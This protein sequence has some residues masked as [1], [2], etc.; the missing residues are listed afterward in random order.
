MRIHLH[1]PTGRIV[2]GAVVGNMKEQTTAY[3]SEVTCNDCLATLSPTLRSSVTEV[4]VPPITCSTY[5]YG[6]HTNCPSSVECVAVGLCPMCG[7]P[8]LKD[9]IDQQVRHMVGL[10]AVDEAWTALATDCRQRSWVIA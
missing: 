2:C 10:G 1:T 9:R 4:P 8:T 6:D 7:C 5:P 3:R